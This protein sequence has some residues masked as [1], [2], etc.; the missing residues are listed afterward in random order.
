MKTRDLTKDQF[1]KALARHAMVMRYAPV[2][3]GK[4]WEDTV[5]FGSLYLDGYRM[6][7]GTYIRDKR[8]TRRDYLA[9]F[10][11]QKDKEHASRRNTRLHSKLQ[12]LYE[13]ATLAREGHTPTV[14]KVAKE[15]VHYVETH[16]VRPFEDAMTELQ[17]RKGG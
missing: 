2:P 17:T 10:I 4:G 13:L 5:E 11:E 7:D 1:D 9:W 16:E 3:K 8:H 6:R 15:I 12:E 14:A